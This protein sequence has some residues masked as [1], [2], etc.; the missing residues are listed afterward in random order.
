MKKFALGVT[1][2]AFVTLAV[3]GSLSACGS[4]GNGSGFEGGKPDGTTGTG[5]DD[6]NGDDGG[7]AAHI[8]LTNNDGSTCRGLA[9]E[10]SST[11]PG[12]ADAGGTTITG[13]VLDPAG[14]NPI[15]NAFVYVP[16]YDP[17]N[18]GAIPAGEGIQPIT[19]GVVFPKGV[20]CDSCSYLY[21]G[22]PIAAANTAADGTFTITNVPAGTNIPLV[23]Q[24]GKWRTHTTV[25]SV[26][27]CGTTSAGSIKLPSSADGSDPIVSMPQFALSMGNS[28]SLEC[29]LYRIGI[30]LKEFTSGPSATGHVHLFT[31]AGMALDGGG[32][33]APA[34]E[35]SLWN[36]LASME[37]YDVSLFSCE[38][39][40]TTGA[41]PKILEQYVNAGGRA[42]TSHFHYSWLAGPIDTDSSEGPY[43]GKTYQQNADWASLASWYN[44]D[45]GVLQGTYFHANGSDLIGVKIDTELNGDAGVFPK[46]EALTQWLTTTKA[47]GTNGVPADEVA[48]QAPAFDSQVNTSDPD[49]QPWATYDPGSYVTGSPGYEKGLTAHQTAYFSFNTPVDAKAT[50]GGAP[51][52]CGRVVFTGLHVGAAAQDKT[53]DPTTNV[54]DLPST[55]TCNPTP[56][57]LSPQ[58]K[59]LEFMLFDLSACVVSDTIAPPSP[60]TIVR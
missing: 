49:S 29:L 25:A 14:A 16:M 37:K 17:A 53:T 18:A 54:Y 7:D 42:F 30:D 51:P 57:N 28:D 6:D 21:T 19:G 56:G 3:G 58:E 34:G 2:V 1:L 24:I 9:C 38:G 50:D 44:A 52:Y 10:I 31:G 13:T 45:P 46:G 23:V 36:T 60:I 8:T 55:M 27:A 47:F 32:A 26:P 48:I 5:D 39:R 4:S 22:N 43:G 12:G 35:D 20:S 15:Y 59:I 41:D 11:C 33:G 40:E